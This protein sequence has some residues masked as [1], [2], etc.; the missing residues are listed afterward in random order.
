LH[1]IE[2]INPIKSEVK[3]IPQITIPIQMD[4]NIHIQQQLDKL[5]QKLEIYDQFVT[6][7]FVTYHLFEHRAVN[8]YLPINTPCLSIMSVS[9][10]LDIDDCFWKFSRVGK[11]DINIPYNFE[12]NDLLLSTHTK[13]QMK[14]LLK[15]VTYYEKHFNDWITLDGIGKKYEQ[16]VQHLH[17]CEQILLCGDSQ[18]TME[19]LYNGVM[20]HI[21]IINTSCATLN[22]YQ[23]EHCASTLLK[24]TLVW[25]PNLTTFYDILEKLLFLKELTFVHCFTISQFEI[26]TI[27]DYCQNSNIE[28]IYA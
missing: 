27:R 3:D 18:Y 9:K 23:L 25:L 2:P 21:H 14:S 16:N 28:F 12:R 5:S 7:P 13:K 4:N 17:K 8:T 24:L 26:K 22:S 19:L 11:P 10:I 15:W 20:N 1:I 6:I